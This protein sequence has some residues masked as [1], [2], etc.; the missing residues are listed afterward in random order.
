M[1]ETVRASEA[2]GC[3]HQAIDVAHRQGARSFELRAESS[4]ARLWQ[5]QGKTAEARQALSK[6]YGDFAEGF[7]TAD[8]RDA[9]ALLDEL[10]SDR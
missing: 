4:L 1:V 3:F 7:D 2:E 5:R 8:L 6:V 9:K 10:A